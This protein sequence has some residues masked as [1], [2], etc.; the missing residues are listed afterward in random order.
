MLTVAVITTSTIPS[1]LALRLSVTA[2]ELGA[3]TLK[4][5]GKLIADAVESVTCSVPALKS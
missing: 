5:D 1:P 2:I 3:V 4:G